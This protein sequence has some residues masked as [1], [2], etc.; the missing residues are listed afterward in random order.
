MCLWTTRPSLKCISHLPI[1]FQT[2]VLRTTSNPLSLVTAARSEVLA[3]NKDQPI[4]N[5]HTMEELVSNS[6]AQRRFNMLLLSIFATVALLL[7]AVGI[8]GVMSYSVAQRTHELGLRMAL[9]AQS[10]HVVA[11]VV[12][13]GMMLA[14]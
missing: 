11:L 9:G 3:V 10:S 1:F 4:S 6:I 12:R 2:I 8:Y 7:S 13:Q 5:V 14:L